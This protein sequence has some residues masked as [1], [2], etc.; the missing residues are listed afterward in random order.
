M[1]TA[2]LAKDFTDL[3]KAGDFETPGHRYW[4]E[5]VVSIEPMAEVPPSVGR[6]A[7]VAKGVWWYENHEVHGAKVD[8]PWVHGDQFAVR[9]TI[10]VTIKATG[11]RMA[12]DEIG[13]YTVRDG[14]V[15]EERFF[16]GG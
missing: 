14:K 6:D 7:V 3:L 8:G 9:F 11:Q 15:V 4:S 2:T 1:D 13:V 12:M 16:Y 10:D 5:D